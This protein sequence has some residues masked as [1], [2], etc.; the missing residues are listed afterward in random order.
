MRQLR[1]GVF[2][3]QRRPGHELY[4]WM[5]FLGLIAEQL[6]TWLLGKVRKAT[7]VVEQLRCARQKSKEKHNERL[8]YLIARLSTRCC[9]SDSQMG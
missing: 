1:E 7:C 6:T 9:L 8:L 2:F 3:F 5:L 4:Y